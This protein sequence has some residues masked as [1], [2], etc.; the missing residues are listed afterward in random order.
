MYTDNKVVKAW[1][2]IEAWGRE[3]TGDS[4]LADI[5]DTAINKIK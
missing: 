1:A 2:E 3:I 4:E 5:C